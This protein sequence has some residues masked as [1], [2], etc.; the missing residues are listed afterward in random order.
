MYLIGLV[1]VCS[2]EYLR[3]NNDQKELLPAAFRLVV[4]SRFLSVFTIE[5]SKGVGRGKHYWV[6]KP[7]IF[8]L[9]IM[10]KSKSTTKAYI[11]VVHSHVVHCK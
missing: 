4:V 1:L 10:K 2:D 9:P 6:E 11:M 3:F 8:G 7:G 5:N